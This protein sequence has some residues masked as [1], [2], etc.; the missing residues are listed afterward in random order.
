MR[1][2]GKI[3]CDRE[4]GLECHRMTVFWATV[5]G[6]SFFGLLVVFTLVAAGYLKRR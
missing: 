2:A 1:R 3:G 5:I 4:D 6:W